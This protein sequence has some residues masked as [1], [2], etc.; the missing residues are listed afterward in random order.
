VWSPL[1]RYDW[2]EDVG[3]VMARKLRAVRCYRSQLRVFRYDAAVRGLNR[4][5]GVLG[6]GSRYAE[7]FCTLAAR[8]P[9]SSEA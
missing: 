4:Y 8:P 5:R 1:G 2:V 9:Q 7:A 3:A 6:A